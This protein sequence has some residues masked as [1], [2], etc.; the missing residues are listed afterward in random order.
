[1]NYLEAMKATI[2]LAKE[3]PWWTTKS[4]CS[5]E[6]LEKM[7]RK[8]LKDELSEVKLANMLGWMQAIVYCFSTKKLK[9]DDFKKINKGCRK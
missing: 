5:I 4:G 8:A 2:L 7:Y 1:M 3:Q 6:Y 9:V